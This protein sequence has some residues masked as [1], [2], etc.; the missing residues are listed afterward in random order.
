M[1]NGWLR[2]KSDLRV[3]P[4]S[5]RHRQQKQIDKLDANTVNFYAELKDI[6]QN[7][8]ELTEIE[9]PTL[10]SGETDEQETLV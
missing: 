3:P 4:R 5:I 6:V 9:T 8:P 2:I 7:L 10:S 1:D